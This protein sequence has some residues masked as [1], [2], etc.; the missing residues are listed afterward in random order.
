MIPYKSIA[1]CII[2]STFFF[3]LPPSKLKYQEKPFSPGSAE[4]TIHFSTTMGNIYFLPPSSPQ[5]GPSEFCLYLEMNSEEQEKI[6]D[7][8][9]PLNISLVL[10]K[11]GSMQGDNIKYVKIA[12]NSIIKELTKEDKLSIVVYNNSS[13]VLMTTVNVNNPDSVSKIINNVLADGGTNIEAGLVKG[14]GELAANYDKNALNKLILLSDGMANAGITNPQQLAKIA[15]DK[16]MQ[17]NISLSSFGVGK[18]FN[19]DLMTSLAESGSGNYYFIDSAGKVESILQQEFNE[20]MN[21]QGINARITVQL[22]EG[23]SL[24]KS[25]GYAVTQNNNSLIIELGDIFPYDSKG[26]LLKFKIDDPSKQNYN[27]NS[28][29][30]YDDPF[31]G[32]RTKYITRINSIAP[33]SDTNAYKQNLDLSVMQQAILFESNERLA[34]AIKEIDRDQY[35]NARKLVA[36]N[37][38]YLKEQFTYFTPTN[39]LLMQD[40]MNTAYELQIKDAERMSKENKM[41]MQKYNKMNTYY[42]EKKRMD[43]NPYYKGKDKLM[44]EKKAKYEKG[45]G[46]GY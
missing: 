24:A 28:T 26:I 42:M 3:K 30:S 4:N 22:P 17:N 2:F 31:A 37:R 16:K 29:L 5:S 14:Y 39:E 43:K 33:T 27:F 44:E 32:N 38:N 7:N 36:E 25:Y 8:R 41:M 20:I 6:N 45:K 19:E 12:C 34:L 11:S 35:N 18:S 1:A 13:Q 40:S 46:K 21:I 9:M 10:D 23:I 15:S